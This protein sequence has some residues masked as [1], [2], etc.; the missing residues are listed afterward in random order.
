MSTTRY[1]G[2]C[3]VLYGMDVA[4]GI[5]LARAEEML[6]TSRRVRLQHKGRVLLE[7]GGVSP[8]LR[9]GWTAPVLEVG[10]WRTA[11]E[12]GI[13]IYDL[14]AVAIT[15]SLRFESSLEELIQL[16]ALLYDNEPLIARSH[17]LAREVL[18]ALGAAAER[19]KPARRLEDYVVLQIPQVEGGPTRL[20]AEAGPILARVLRAEPGELSAQ[21]IG[22]AL[23]GRIAY[24]RHDAC[25]V[26]WNAALLIGEDT[27]DERQVLEL[28]TVGLLELR[29]LD[30]HL[31]RDLGTAYELVARPRGVMSALTLQRRELEQVAR[32]QADDALLREGLD[33]ALKIFG[34]DYLARLYSTA[35]ERFHF[36]DWEESI[37]RKLQVLRNVYSSLADLAAHRR[38]EA[39]EWIIILLIAGE[40]V[41]ALTIL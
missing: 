17:E 35:A 40:I 2:T 14:G 33:N 6:V 22:E 38:S 4:R 29:E 21:E 26:D 24:G 32:M 28:A 30:G 19:P 1:A 9:V 25:F 8:P 7:E 37:E 3:R 15:W 5:D 34:D 10:S 13:S 12:V 16:A 41:M 23:G 39:L 20:L 36:H 27:E 18:G 11:G 31:E